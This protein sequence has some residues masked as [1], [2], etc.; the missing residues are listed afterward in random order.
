MGKNGQSLGGLVLAATRD[1]G[2][3]IRKLPIVGDVP[4]LLGHEGSASAVYWPALARLVKPSWAVASGRFKRQRHPASDPFNV[5]LNYLAWLLARD[6]EVLIKR[7]GL[8]PGSARCTVP[9]MA[10]TPRSTILWRS[11]A[12]R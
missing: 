10:R 8:H 12:R 1:L 2:A 11:S 3:V 6:V 5:V 4:A 9:S 7:H